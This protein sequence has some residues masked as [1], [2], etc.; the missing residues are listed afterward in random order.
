LRR[1]AWAFA[2]AVLFTSIAVQSQ[3]EFAA[4]KPAVQVVSIEA[5]PLTKGKAAPV[6]L[7]FRVTPGFHVNS[8]KPN[9]ELL[10]PTV[11]KLDTPTDFSLG[12]IQYPDGEQLSLSFSPS[13][14]LSVYTGDFTV[15]ATARTIGAVRPGSYRV[16]GELH[17]QACDNNACYPP[18]SVP[19]AFDVKV[20]KAKPKARGNPAQSPHVHN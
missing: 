17:Y 13:E 2:I 20:E 3:D 6:A 8:N 12:N 18:K 7:K 10:I 14:K 5:A 9:S 16:H 15:Q 11:L 4:R 19:V 1:N